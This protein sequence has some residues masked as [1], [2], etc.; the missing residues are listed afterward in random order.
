MKTKKFLLLPILS[1]FCFSACPPRRSM[2]GQTDEPQSS[3]KPSDCDHLTEQ[4]QNFAKKLSAI[5]RHLFCTQFTAV[6]RA[7]AMAIAAEGYAPQG[8]TPLT[9][10]EAVEKSIQSSSISFF[11]IKIYSHIHSIIK[12]IMTNTVR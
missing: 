4:E 7:E 1:L 10:D 2:P 3:A 5:H 12:D 6:M 11:L 9:P 8:Q